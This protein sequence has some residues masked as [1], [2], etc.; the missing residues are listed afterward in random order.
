MKNRTTKNMKY[1][2]F[3]KGKKGKHSIN[4]YLEAI[5]VDVDQEMLIKS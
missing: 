1:K 4:S 3:S 5:R 2:N